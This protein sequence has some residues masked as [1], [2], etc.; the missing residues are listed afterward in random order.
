MC[1]NSGKPAPVPTTPA[2]TVSPPAAPSPFP[3]VTTPG[4]R[5]LSKYYSKELIR[6]VA[7]SKGQD[8]T[9]EELALQYLDKADRVRIQIEALREIL[10][11]SFRMKDYPSALAKPHLALWSNSTGCVVAR[12]HPQGGYQPTGDE[13]LIQVVNHIRDNPQFFFE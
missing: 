9:I 12:K 1:P 2:A 11:P 3:T 10:G 13:E 6:V 4:G 7:C 5:D 8:A